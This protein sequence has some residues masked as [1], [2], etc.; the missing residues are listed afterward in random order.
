MTKF[1][2]IIPALCMLLISAVLMGTSTY[3]WFSMNT[4]V[5]A[6]GMTVSASTESA[7]LIIKEGTTLSGNGKEAN[8]KV[9]A[10]LK[11][12]A[13]A[14]TLTSANIETLGSWGVA[15]SSNPDDANEGADL[16][17]LT[18]G[19]LIGDG[20]YVLKQSFMVG[21][22]ANSGSVNNDLRLKKVTIEN[23]NGKNGVVVVVVCGTNIY[24][25]ETS[26]DNI[27]GETLTAAAN[28]NKT[29]VQVD[30]YIYIN[31]KN[32]DVKSS[33]ATQLGGLVSLDFTI[34]A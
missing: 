21:I 27:T 23:N 13:P 22:V 24:T 26:A 6:T 20:N 29:G 14:T 18:E 33:Q 4:T 17:V 12:V 2:K 30:V 31:G 3:A 15:T 1:K 7:Y 19:T 9:S 34:D 5:T 28:V 8:A 32:A 25:H 16:T 11:P 10:S